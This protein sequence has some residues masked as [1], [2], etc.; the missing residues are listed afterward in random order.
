M[1]LL[2]PLVLNLRADIRNTLI[3]LCQGE[4]RSTIEGRARADDAAKQ[5]LADD[6]AAIAHPNGT[7][8]F[9]D[10]FDPHLGSIALDCVKGHGSSVL[11]GMTDLFWERLGQLKEYLMEQLRVAI[12]LP[13]YM[14]PAREHESLEEGEGVDVSRVEEEQS[15]AIEWIVGR[16]LE[17]VQ[18]ISS[19]TNLSRSEDATGKEEGSEEL[20]VISTDDNEESVGSTK[21]AL[22]RSPSQA[23]VRSRPIAA[24]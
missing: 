5:A 16:F 19:S 23:R 6:Q 10:L 11:K 12:G 4:P 20:N 17:R 8:Y 13:R 22:P 14:S 2:K 18:S 3:W 21:M 15:R 9:M 24:Q 7:V 1:N